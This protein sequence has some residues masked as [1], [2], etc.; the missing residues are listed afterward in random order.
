MNFWL[1]R[2]ELYFAHERVGSGEEVF[3]AD[4]VGENTFFFFESGVL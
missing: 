2:G 1:V 4:D 3:D